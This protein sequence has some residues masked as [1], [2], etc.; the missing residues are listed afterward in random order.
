MS[1]KHLSYTIEEIYL[2]LKQGK[3]NIRESIF[4]VHVALL[5]KDNEMKRVTRLLPIDR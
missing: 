1:N 4:L 2:M 5:A 3:G